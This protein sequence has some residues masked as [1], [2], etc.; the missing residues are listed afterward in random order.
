M[1]GVPPLL[2]PACSCRLNLGKSSVPFFMSF[3]YLSI[4]RS[5]D[6]LNP[7]V[8]IATNILFSLSILLHTFSAK[9]RIYPE[10]SKFSGIFLFFIISDCSMIS[11][12][13]LLSSFAVPLVWCY[14]SFIEA[15]MN[16]F[17]SEN[18][19]T[20]YRVSR[21]SLR[22]YSMLLMAS[23][24]VAYIIILETFKTD[25]LIEITPMKTS[26]SHLDDAVQKDLY[27]Y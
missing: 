15:M 17:N 18:R 21:V 13:I 5:V 1:R 3:T 19:L 25:V 6:S 20:P 7:S 10:T 22:F 11:D 2:N 4:S 8:C 12:L 23:S 24:I 26:Q 27:N 9:I 14:F 16:F